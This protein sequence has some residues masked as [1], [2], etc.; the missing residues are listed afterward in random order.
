[1]G[2]RSHE[3]FGAGRGHTLDLE[4]KGHRM[5]V[6]VTIGESNESR[7]LEATLSEL[8]HEIDVADRGRDALERVGRGSFD[9]VIVGTALPDMSTAEF[10]GVLRRLQVSSPILVYGWNDVAAKVQALDAGADDC[11]V[12]PVDDVELAARLR[13]VVRRG[14]AEEGAWLRCNGLEMHLT[15]RTVRAEGRML[16]LTPREFTVLEQLLRHRDRIVG[17]ALL[18]ERVWGADPFEN[19]SNVVDV[20][21]SRLRRKLRAGGGNVVIRTVPGSGYTL[22][23][24]MATEAA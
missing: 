1:M 9:A 23:S 12:P 22:A 5:R 17:R 19:G 2:V 18:R 10:V 8:G 11:V 24:E 20:Y 15:T 13:A 21:V 4:W 16:R 14:T 7:Q 3:Y 6:L